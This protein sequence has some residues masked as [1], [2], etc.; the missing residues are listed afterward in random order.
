MSD[1]ATTSLA[2]DEAQPSRLGRKTRVALTLFDQGVV[3]IATYA[4]AVLMGR[5]S[6]SG[7]GLYMLVFT[8]WIFAT[9]LHNSLVSTPQMVK[10]PGMRKARK[11]E[12]NGSLLLHQ[13]AL[14]GMLTLVMLVGALVLFLLARTT[15]DS[16]KLNTYGFVSLMGALSVAPVALRNFARNFCFTIRDV[17]SAVILD[18][19]VSVMQVLGVALAFFTNELG[20]HWYLAVLIVSVSN[21]FSAL[22]WLSS[23]RGQ[24]SPRMKRAVVDFRRNWGISR[25]IFLSSMVWT[26]GTYLYPWLIS[27][28]KGDRSAG[29][30]AVC[31]TLAN[32]GNPII[33]AIQNMMGPAISHAFVGLSMGEFRRYVFKCTILFVTVGGA[34]AVMLALLSEPLIVLFNGKDYAGYGK[35]SALLAAMMLL[36]G[37]SFPT[38]RGLFSLDRAKLDMYA[39]L[40]PIAVMAVLGVFL[41]GRYDVMG[42]A[43]CLVLAQIIGSISRILFFL[44]ASAEQCQAVPTLADKSG[45]TA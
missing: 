2:P 25:F 41:I 23:V 4:T 37:L 17:P 9:E 13:L 31:F 12:F 26:A 20:H 1:R 36:Q 6:Q 30:W 22:L 35:V 3:S 15:A 44:H 24:F 10:L 34:G 39:N 5:A 11:A 28:L 16:A 40:G 8:L 32:L 18:V 43:I 33:T 27:A 29:I 7:V 21:L 42:A 14:S 19:G 38:S 45:A